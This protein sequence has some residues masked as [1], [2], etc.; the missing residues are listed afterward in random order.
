[1]K[2]TVDQ[3][4]KAKSLAPDHIAKFV[5][6]SYPAKAPKA[7]KPER[8]KAPKAPKAPSAPK[9]PRVAPA[10]TVQGF[11]GDVASASRDYLGL[12]A[13]DIAASLRSGKSLGE[14][15][16]A[17][18]GKTRTGLI[19]TV[20]ALTNAKIDKAQ[21]DGKLTMD[22]ATSLKATV[23]SAVTAIVDRKGPAAAT[24]R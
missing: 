19:A 18:A 23:L 9:A 13:Q 3:A 5:D 14:L 21:Q 15:A 8:P 12:T 17:T 16:D 6:H 24:T 1:A 22:Q 10:P 2:I 7:T 20:T 4:T 11:I